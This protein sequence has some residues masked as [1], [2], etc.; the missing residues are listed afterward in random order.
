MASVFYSKE[1][2]FEISLKLRAFPDIKFIWFGHLPWILRQSKVNKA[3]RR[4]PNN[5]ILPGY[6]ANDIIKG[7]MQ[8]AEMLFSQAMKK[9]KELLF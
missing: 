4:K 7:A 2:E 9:Q 8:Y 1:K 6:I 5:V 3:I